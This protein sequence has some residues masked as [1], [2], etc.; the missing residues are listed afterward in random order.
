MQAI[1]DEAIAD[2]PAGAPTQDETIDL[3]ARLVDERCLA[4]EGLPDVG[5]LRE[6]DRRR[7]SKR[8]AGRLNPLSPRV[9]IGD[10]TPW[11]RPFEGFAKHAFSPAGALAWIALA[12]VAAV[13]AVGEWDAILLHAKRFTAS[14]RQWLLA[15]LIWIPMKALHEAAHALAVRRWGGTVR[16]AGLSWMMGLPVP[17]VDASAADRFPHARQRAAVAAAGILVETALAALG[18]VAWA[19]TEPGWVNDTAFAVALAGTTSTLLFNGNPLMRMDGYFVLCDLAGLP[20]LGTRSGAW[21]RAALQRALGWADAQPPR[22]APGE[23]PWL[24]VYAPL[25]W[26]WRAGLMASLTLWAGTHHR[27]AGAAVAALS[28]LWLL[29]L[30]LRATLRGPGEA[31]ARASVRFRVRTRA[32]AVLAA[33]TAVALAV[34]L[35]DRTV[36]PGL[37]RMP[38]D[39]W[40]RAGVDGFVTVADATGRDVR[41]GDALV[42]LDDPALRQE[43]ERLV[44]ARPG[45]RAEL[46]ANLRTDPARARQAEEALA[47]LE[48]EL[49]SVDE[50]LGR[51]EVRAAADG[52]FEVV[53]PSD[54]PGRF[55]REGDPIGVIVG[56]APAHVRVALDQDAA[57][58]LRD[59]VRGVELRLEEAPGRPLPGRLLR[60]APAAVDA[61]PGAALGER[62]GG[63]IPVDPADEDGLKPA[64]PTYV[65]DVS[66]DG[67]LEPAPRPGGRAWVRIDHGH[68]SL[69]GQTWRWLRQTVRGRFSP[70]AL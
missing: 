50:R 63:P 7:A 36:A 18:L 26:G 57:A 39:A 37:V 47:S 25:A 51:L 41:A 62:F 9:A 70:D 2:D 30:P 13:M 44:Q 58:R 32:L 55:V 19:M 22:A 34:P 52:R 21:W 65:V 8:L 68:A 10:P 12:A 45:L 14:P 43:H 49:A 15:M 1:W 42:R 56:S 60:Q 27:L 40:V 31:G 20:N 28:V 29:V 67:T 59:G 69:A 48:A 4:C 35:P 66:I 53:R 33:L 5:V 16:E 6:D 24:V 64:H 23:R 61:L 3:L 38:D 46:F 54:L 17:Y 11:L